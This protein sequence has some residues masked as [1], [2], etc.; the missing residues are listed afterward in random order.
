MLNTGD[1]VLFAGLTATVVLN[2]ESTNYGASQPYPKTRIE[3]V[4]GNRETVATDALTPIVRTSIQSIP[5]TDLGMGAV[6]FPCERCGD[7]MDIHDWFE[8]AKG[9]IINCDRA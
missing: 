6:P 7:D 4:T 8:T 1:K 3:Y 9:R 5:A 2:Y